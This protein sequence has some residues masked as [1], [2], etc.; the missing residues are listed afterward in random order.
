MLDRVHMLIAIPPKYTVFQVSRY[1]KGKRAI[2][3]VR[4]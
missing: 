4:T 1:I 3:I 2:H